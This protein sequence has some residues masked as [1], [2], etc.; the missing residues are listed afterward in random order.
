MKLKTVLI[1]SVLLMAAGIFAAENNPLN[2]VVK[3]EVRTSN[4]NYIAPW[5]Q[6]M[7]AA[8]G[9]GVVIGNR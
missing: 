5:Q 4:P 1:G 8:S 7:D 2:A 9:S 6:V 3:L